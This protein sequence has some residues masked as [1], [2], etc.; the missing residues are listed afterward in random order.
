MD[1]RATLLVTL[2]EIENITTRLINKF[3]PRIHDTNEFVLRTR[4]LPVIASNGCEIDFSFGVPGYE[5]SMLARSV[6]FEPAK[7]IQI[8]ICSAEDLIIHKA[9]AGRPHDLQDIVG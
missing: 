6:S 7:G 3:I 8:R 2:E 5:E 9:V 4:V 1:N